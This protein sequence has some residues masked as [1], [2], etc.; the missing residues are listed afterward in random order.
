M[1]PAHYKDVG[2]LSLGTL[3]ITLLTLL[4]IQ[5]SPGLHHITSVRTGTK[6]NAHTLPNTC[7]VNNKVLLG[8]LLVCKLGK[9]SNHFTYGFDIHS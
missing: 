1:L 5:M 2:S 7:A 6:E 3:S 9:V 4:N 8:T